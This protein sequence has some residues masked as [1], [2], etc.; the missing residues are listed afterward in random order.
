MLRTNI[1]HFID[2]GMAFK[3]TTIHGKTHVVH[4]SRSWTRGY[5]TW[6]WH[7]WRVECFNKVAYRRHT[8]PGFFSWRTKQALHIKM[9]NSLISY[10]C[11]EIIKIVMVFW[12]NYQN[13]SSNIYGSSLPMNRGWSLS[14]SANMH[15]IDHQ[16]SSAID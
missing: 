10:K 16:I 5:H 4:V 12:W 2:E 11:R 1:T 7:N 14:I 9:F 15:P 3:V 8:R 13:I 6:L